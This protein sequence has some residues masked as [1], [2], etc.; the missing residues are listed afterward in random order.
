MSNGIKYRVFPN[1]ASDPG[2]F[3]VVSRAARLAVALAVGFSCCD[4]GVFGVVALVDALSNGVLA[5]VFPTCAS[6]PGVFDVV[7]RAAR[8]A[9]TLAVALVVARVVGFSR[10]DPGVFDVVALAV[11]FSAVAIR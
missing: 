1:C 5:R 7:A 11:G 3:D 9:V 8:L 10:C 2:V 6:D 4:P